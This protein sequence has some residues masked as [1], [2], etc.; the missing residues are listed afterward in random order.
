MAIEQD[1]E[2][3]CKVT[4]HENGRV[5]TRRMYAIV[6]QAYDGN[7]YRISGKGLPDSLNLHSGKLKDGKHF[8]DALLDPRLPRPRFFDFIQKPKIRDVFYMWL[9][10]SLVTLVSLAFVTF[11]ATH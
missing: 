5:I 10:A 8:A 7:T 1:G 6:V 4:F 3:Y 2:Y 11:A 9:G